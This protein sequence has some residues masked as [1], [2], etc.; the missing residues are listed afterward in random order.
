MK[1]LLIL[2]MV[3]ALTGLEKPVEV[4]S[5][6]GDL[7]VSLENPSGQVVYSVSYKGETVIGE[8]SLGLVTSI[9][10]LTRDLTLTGVEEAKVEDRYTLRTAKTSQVN[11]V[12]NELK[13]TFEG[14]DGRVLTVTFRVSDSDVAFRYGVSVKHPAREPELHRTLVYSEASSFNFPDG[15][16]TF[17]CPMAEPGS[18]WAHARPSYEEVYTPDA[19][20]DVPSA[21][22]YGYSFPCLFHLGS[23]W[24][25]VSETGVG[26]GYCGAHLGEYQKGKGYAIAY[27]S[28]EENGGYGTAFAAV[29]LP[30]S[31][32]WRTITVGPLKALAETT[33]A[34]DLVEPLYVAATAYQ[35]GRYTWS[36]L[37]WQDSSVNFEDQVQMIDLSAA[38]GF[39]YCLVDNWWDQQIGRDRMAELA[40][41]AQSKGVSLMLW[42]SSNGYW[43]DAP[44]TPKHCMNTAVAREREMQ[45]LRSIGIKGIKVDFFGGDKQETLQ[46]YEDILS[47]ANRFGL[48]VIFHGCTLPRG[49]ERMYP[50][51]VASEAVMASEN[52][53][54]TPEDAAREAFDL[55]IHPF[56]RNAV[57][58]MDWGGVILNRYMS[59]DNRSRHARTTTDTFE[60]ATGIINQSAI[61][62]V[63]L[64]PNNLT[65]V[66]QFE[67]DFLKG[68]PS[69]WDETRY[70]DG[71]P[72]KYV[73]LARRHGDQWYV[74][75]L[76][77]LKE[78]LTLTLDVPMLSGQTV[79]C[80]VDDKNGT[81]TL[82]SL[83][84]K[85][86]GKAKVTLQP[87]GGLI[88]CR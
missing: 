83:K 49:W 21:F 6:S 65:E 59:R 34:Y 28:Q 10:D 35:G 47:D 44:Q 31:T 54:F 66:P 38:M 56:C 85:A 13:A 20:M 1:L 4:T 62:C 25:L 75:G 46:L 69:A 16:T 43:N 55:T 64:Y 2:G 79:R 24:A 73:A 14:K 33:V 41:Y 18:R 7:K 3:A 84:I 8:S 15:T 42:Y 63:A 77:A 80:Y 82:T 12:A 17:I 5:P 48:Q 70:L 72:G 29:P 30:F 23:T 57:A 81:P 40:A 87:N 45:W 9:G 51:F 50:N 32:P 74:A 53:Y 27:P 68:L 58:S 11:Y 78:P 60:L 86:D 67:L 26:S 71:Y 22:G 52:V 19:P 88:L 61:Q 36:W 39:E 37:L 76:N